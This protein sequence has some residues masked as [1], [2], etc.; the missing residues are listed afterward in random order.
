[1]VH[2]KVLSLLT[3][4]VYGTSYS[5]NIDC[6]IVIYKEANM[7]NVHTECHHEYT[8]K[9]KRYKSFSLRT[10]KS[11]LQPYQSLDVPYLVC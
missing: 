2:M 11:S 3:E 6:H 10:M 9:R 1:M 5:M 7:R 8:L 4:M